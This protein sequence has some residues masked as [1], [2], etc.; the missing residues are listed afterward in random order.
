M[1]DQEFDETPIDN[2][3]NDDF[4]DDEISNAIVNEI[5]KIKESKS[6]VEE[7]KSDLETPIENNE[8]KKKVK[9]YEE[10]IK[11]IRIDCE[12]QCNKEL[13]ALKNK[14]VGAY[15]NEMNALTRKIAELEKQNEDNSKLINK[16]NN[17]LSF[18]SKY[19]QQSVL[20]MFLILF[21]IFNPIV[22]NILETTLPNKIPFM[23]TILKVAIAI[24]IYLI[25]TQ[26]YLS[27]FV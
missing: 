12:T 15:E 5:R 26:Q 27:K 6:E 11:S 22:Y 18:K 8:K 21:L 10:D 3:V 9:F 4:T 14:I 23:T 24:F 17:L 16:N 13:D 19:L 2:V 7:F 20:V 25:A 1:Y